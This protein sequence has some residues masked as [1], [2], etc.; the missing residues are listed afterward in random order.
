MDIQGNGDVGDHAFR[1]EDI[2]AAL[3]RLGL[4]GT[5]SPAVEAQRRGEENSADDYCSSDQ[6]AGCSPGVDD[7]SSS[8]TD[9]DLPHRPLFDVDTHTCQRVPRYLYRV[10]HPGSHSITHDDG[11]VRARNQNPN[12]SSLPRFRD[13]LEQHFQWNLCS[14]SPFMS[15]F[16]SIDRTRDW[17]RRLNRNNPDYGEANICFCMVD[18]RRLRTSPVFDAEVL[19]AD[20]N[21]VVTYGREENLVH[22][23]AEYLIKGCI[24]AAAIVHRG[25]WQDWEGFLQ[26]A[27]RVERGQ[28][29]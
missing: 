17:T 5:R 3:E 11:T 23:T 9:D 13:S 15:V 24:D 19:A 18:T 14:P 4:G 1:P 21:I 16:S 22:H 12:L 20:L 8:D 10:E 2:T 7:S 29:T 26:G 6:E 25:T 28:E 27:I